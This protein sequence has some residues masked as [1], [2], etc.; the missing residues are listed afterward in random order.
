MVS[1]ATMGIPG[2]NFATCLAFSVATRTTYLSGRSPFFSVSSISAGTISVGLKPAFSKS[3]IRRGDDDAKIKIIVA[4]LKDKKPEA[5]IAEGLKK[6]S[7]VAPAGG[8]HHEE[9]E[10]KKTDKGK[11]K[12][13]KDKGKGGKDNKPAEKPAKAPEPEEDDIDLGGLF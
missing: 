11:D 3:R 12:G 2:R 13:G 10:D 7:A 8:E 1:A 5:V 9:H 6:L 4:A